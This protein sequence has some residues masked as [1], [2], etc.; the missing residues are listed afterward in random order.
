MWFIK[1]LDLYMR[2]LSGKHEVEFL[3][4]MDDDDRTMKNAL[5]WDYLIQIE[6]PDDSMV[7]LSWY[8]KE[9]RGKVAAFNSCIAAHD[10]DILVPISDDVEPQE[11][12]YDDIIARDMKAVFPDLDGVIYY[13]DGRCHKRVVSIPIFGRKFFGTRQY[14]THPNFVAWGDNYTSDTLK[15]TNKLKYCRQVL[16]KHCHT[17]YA[18]MDDTYTRAANHKIADARTAVIMKAQGE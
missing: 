9:H 15:K 17:K 7:R 12:G 10:W 14:I 3:I 11:V 1:T 8:Y 13:S 6:P 16:L 4:A 5:I 2:M 18:R